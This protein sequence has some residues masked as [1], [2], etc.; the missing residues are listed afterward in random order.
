[1]RNILDRFSPLNDGCLAQGRPT[2]AKLQSLEPPG[3]EDSEYVI[4]KFI[5]Y[6]KTKRQC[7]TSGNIFLQPV[8]RGPCGKNFYKFYLKKDTLNGF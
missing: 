7:E 3:H 8:G 2:E 4:K 5:Q 6:L 1:M